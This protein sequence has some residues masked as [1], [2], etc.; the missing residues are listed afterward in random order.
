MK[1]RI[2]TGYSIT[3]QF[4]SG[5]SY[6]RCFVIAV[7]R[8]QVGGRG[9]SSIFL[10]GEGGKS[11]LSSPNPRMVLPLHQRVKKNA[12][13]LENKSHFANFSLLFILF[14]CEKNN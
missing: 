10:V 3:I 4:G 5:V 13:H 9:K 1:D 11:N 12:K 8:N 2:F 7:F 6:F 14:V